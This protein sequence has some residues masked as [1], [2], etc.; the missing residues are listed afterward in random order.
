MEIATVTTPTTES[1]AGSD[2]HSFLGDIPAV[3]EGARQALERLRAQNGWLAGSDIVS[4][5]IVVP[6]VRGGSVTADL[7]NIYTRD[8]VGPPGLVEILVQNIDALCGELNRAGVA[9]GDPAGNASGDVDTGEALEPESNDEVD[10]EEIYRNVGYCMQ[11]IAVCVSINGQAGTGVP[12]GETVVDL[13]LPARALP[14][15]HRAIAERA[16][17][18]GTQL[19]GEYRRQ[20]LAETTTA[21]VGRP[22]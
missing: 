15:F 16:I 2:E 11:A 4:V 9:G 3:H 12:G 18:L 19:M 20:V 8:L 6:A 17:E 7:E 14:R 5:H 21:T 1:V 13:M 22:G 10:D